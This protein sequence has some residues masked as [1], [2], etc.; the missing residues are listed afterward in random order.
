MVSLLRPLLSA[1]TL[2]L[3]LVMIGSFHFGQTDEE[4]QL[5]RQFELD[6]LQLKIN[7]TQSK[8]LEV[9]NEIN[10]PIINLETSQNG[11]IYISINVGIPSQH[12]NALITTYDSN[13]WVMSES[14]LECHAS[15]KFNENKS[16]SFSIYDSNQQSINF[17]HAGLSGPIAQDQFSIKDIFSTQK[18]SFLLVKTNWRLEALNAIA[19]FPLA[20][21][22]DLF[23]LID[24]KKP[25]IGLK[26]DSED[27]TLCYGN[28]DKSIVK[29]ETKIQWLPISLVKSSNS[30]DNSSISN[31]KSDKIDW[32][33]IIGSLTIGKFQ[34][35]NII[36]TIDTTSADLAI[37]F[38]DYF[39]VKE[40]LLNT[41]AN[42][43]V[44][45]SGFFVCRCESDYKKQFNGIKFDNPK[46]EYEPED[47]LD[48]LYEGKCKLAIKIN[49]ANNAWIFGRNSLINYYFLF[50]YQA[51][52]L[53][54][55]SRREE[56]ED[57]Q[58]RKL[59]IYILIITV[60][61]SATFFSFLYHLYKRAINDERS[62]VNAEPIES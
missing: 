34:K 55:Y 21:P 39:E 35:L 12:I 15:E 29:N 46:F 32:Y 37:P 14:C 51:E 2:F 4:K 25:L 9:E 13:R 61:T 26:I 60:I 62:Q 1:T 59:F 45:P 48:N 53:G 7:N 57:E 31:P 28:Y 41:K 10:D 38:N 24:N 43:Q 3:S 5:Y 16:T 18:Q 11:N 50:D 6:W 23:P 44:Q 20:F 27:S 54:M 36:A 56:N 47:Y 52:R 22:G 42:C 8:I 17:T 58:L 33:F 30:P 40:K 49:Y 19:S